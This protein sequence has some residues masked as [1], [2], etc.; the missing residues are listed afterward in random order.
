MIYQEVGRVTEI[1]I[2]MTGLAALLLGIICGNLYAARKT[3]GQFKKG[4]VLPCSI[5]AG[6]YSDEIKNFINYNGSE[7]A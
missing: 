5:K 1:A 3:S 2:I 6:C 4:V 7:Q